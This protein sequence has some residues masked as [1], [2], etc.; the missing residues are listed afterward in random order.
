MAVIG[1][2]M[3]KRYFYILFAF[4]L[5]SGPLMAERQDLHAEADRPGAGT[6]T[7]VLPFGYIQWETGVEV[8][9]TLG[10]HILTLPTTLFRFGLHDRVELRLE[11]TGGLYVVDKPDSDPLTPDE[12]GMY[13]PDPLCIGT[14]IKLWE[15]SEEQKLRWIPRTSLML[16]LGIPLTK[17]TAEI[18][19][20]AGF[21]D[22]LFENDVT[23]WLTIGYE[24]GAHWREWAPMPDFFASLGL[25]FSA[26]DKLGFF[27]ENYNYFDCDVDPAIF[28]HST[29]FDINL[30][31]GMT[32]MPVPP[33]Q[34]DIYAGFN[35]YESEPILSGPQNFCFLGLGVTWLLHT[36]KPE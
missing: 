25:N 13:V 34:L 23:D 6:G 14:K 24:F 2:G 29:A 10:T 11:Y 21:A 28:G 15:G 32:Y 36:P 9:H 30:N 18:M 1:S 27:V 4:T 19:P 3:L 20:V 12:S 33:V 22:L 26:T 7:N 31:F 35:C 5:L 17:K 8:A 16:N